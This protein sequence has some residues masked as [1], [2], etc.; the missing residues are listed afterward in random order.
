MKNQILNTLLVITIFAF[1]T[2]N[3]NALEPWG[4]SSDKGGKKGEE[5]SDSKESS[6]EKKEGKS[7]E[8]KDNSLIG[9][10]KQLKKGMTMGQ[11]KKI[12]G[13]DPKYLD[14]GSEGTIWTY[15]NSHFFSGMPGTKTI[16][17]YI[18]FDSEGKITKWSTTSAK[19]SYF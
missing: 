3:I 18:S 17:L 7:E 6:E 11:V 2:N 15:T 8:K 9:K 13:G 14:E 1:V 12:M 16:T 19:G 5:S 4:S 10:A